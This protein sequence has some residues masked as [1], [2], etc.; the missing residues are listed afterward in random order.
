MR[1]R[2][3]MTVKGGK[4][5]QTTVEKSADREP[6][7]KN[8]APKIQIEQ[9]TLM[10]GLWMAAWLFTIGYLHLSFW[11]GC[12]ALI[13]WPYFIGVHVSALAR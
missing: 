12:F 9:H 6:G 3:G 7:C 4:T 1:P 2:L 5:V 13:V 11:K 8:F 10:G